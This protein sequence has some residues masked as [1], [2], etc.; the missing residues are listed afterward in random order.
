MCFLLPDS[1]I[2]TIFEYTIPN[3]YVLLPMINDSHIYLHECSA[4]PNGFDMMMSNHPHHIST[5]LL[6]KNHDDRAISY[7]LRIPS[8]SINFIYFIDNPCDTAVDYI[9]KH[10]TELRAT[11]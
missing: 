3:H 1:L 11:Y 2:I 4:N 6:S 9:C 8:I 10:Y 7:L 5:F